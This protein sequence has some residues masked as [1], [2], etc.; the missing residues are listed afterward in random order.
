M[1]V[2]EGKM[3]ED[4]PEERGNDN[5]RGWRWGVWGVQRQN[6]AHWESITTA[7][8]SPSFRVHSKEA[9]D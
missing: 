3:V 6:A 2:I 9:A 8:S 7:S 4:R 1:S 5:G